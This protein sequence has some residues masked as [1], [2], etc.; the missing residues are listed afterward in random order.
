MKIKYLG[1]S[2]LLIETK[3]R[4]IIV[5]PFISQNPAAAQIKVA[6][7]RADA[8]LVTHGHGDHV[9]DVMAIAGQND[10]MV[11]GAFEVVEWFGKQGV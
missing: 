11:I 5:D 3:K 7:L 10:A 2:S 9:A 4:T 8:I 6:D 1:H